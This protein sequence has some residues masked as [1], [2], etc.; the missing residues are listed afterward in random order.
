MK[1][2]TRLRAL[3]LCAGLALGVAASAATAE[4]LPTMDS[5]R[6]RIAVY[7]DFPPYSDHGKGV[8][9]AIGREL[10]KRLG[11]E[12]EI[13]G[14]T[15]DEDMNDDLRNMV[16]KGHYLG[17]RP[18]D[19]M[20]HV[21]VDNYLAQ[22]NEQVHIFGPYHLESVAIARNAERVPPVS[23]SAARAL[24]VFTREKMGVE[25][26]SL[27]DD[28]MLA[29]LNGR[30]RENVSHFPTVNQAVAA[31]QK[32]EVSAVMATRAELESALGTDT[33]YPITPVEMPE[34]RI[35]GWPLGM[36]VKADNG[37]LEAALREALEA[38]YRD[39]TL[40]RIFAEH[41]ITHRTP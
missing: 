5:G 8:D 34:L 14:F 15:A 11:L 36:A 32:G 26:A 24:E 18:A 40:D 23:G 10:A 7:N 33:K 4:T 25:T 17:T 20:L 21:P 19:V 31:L 16:W 39:G 3:L 22:K 27:A 30:L 6:L 12:A 1:N 41:G 28:F 29:V 13:V 9:V 35:K 2:K 38:I 37:E